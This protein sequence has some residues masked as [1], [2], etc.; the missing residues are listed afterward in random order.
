MSYLFEY[1]GLLV[2]AG[3]F[4]FCVC[5]CCGRCGGKVVNYRR[6]PAMKPCLIGFLIFGTLVFLAG[7]GIEL[8]GWRFPKFTSNLIHK[9][10][11]P[12]KVG[13][14]VMVV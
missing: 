1:I 3:I 10:L 8:T 7:S 11:H 4:L 14:F 13:E 6:R 9:N 5:W 12:S 2:L